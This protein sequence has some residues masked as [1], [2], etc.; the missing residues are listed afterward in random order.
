MATPNTYPNLDL[1]NTV[2]LGNEA[3]DAIAD[4]EKLGVLAV[5][6]PSNSGTPTWPV[7]SAIGLRH[8]C[9]EESEGV[10]Y[11]TF[12]LAGVG[13]GLR[14][15]YD[16]AYSTEPQLIIAQIELTPDAN[17]TRVRYVMPVT[18]VGHRNKAASSTIAYTARMTSP[19]THMDDRRALTRATEKSS[20]V[21]PNEYYKAGQ[22]TAGVVPL[23]RTGM[24]SALRQGRL[25]GIR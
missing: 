22:S 20:K 12:D 15:A 19:G 3:L 24:V 21:G 9:E 11:V 17:T 10:P 5:V 14:K 18:T 6:M 8:G 13:S 1:T 16:K 2:K 7:E 4:P 23:G 25:G